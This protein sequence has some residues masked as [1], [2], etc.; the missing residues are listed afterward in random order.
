MARQLD[1][2]RILIVG[3]YRD[4]ESAPE[5]PLGDSLARLSSL[6]SFQRQTISGLSTEE[7]GNFVQVETGFTPQVPLLKRFTPTPRAI[8]FGRISHFG[9]PKLVQDCVVTGKAHANSVVAD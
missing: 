6:A 7:V 9:Y 4:N 5:T 1:G 3:T 2:S 8:P